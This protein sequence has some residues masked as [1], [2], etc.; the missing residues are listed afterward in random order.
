MQI[1]HDRPE[2]THQNIS[3]QK[4][5]EIRQKKCHKKVYGNRDA[6]RYHKMTKKRCSMHNDLISCC[7]LTKCFFLSMQSFGVHYVTEKLEID[8]RKIKK[9]RFL[10]TYFVLQFQKRQY[11]RTAGEAILIRRRYEKN[12]STYQMILFH[13]MGLYYRGSVN[14]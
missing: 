13:L 3:K 10:S 8:N 6:N 9:R 2:H 5:E 1:F 12:L 11:K 7:G 4:R 14:L